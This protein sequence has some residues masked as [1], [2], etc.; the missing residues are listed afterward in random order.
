MA[1]NPR[2]TQ[3]ARS[4]RQIGA[5]IAR[6]RHQRGWT[7]SDL[8]TQAG[9]RQATISAIETGQHPARI[10]SLLA[11]LAA[12]DL[13]FRIGPRAQGQAQDIEDIF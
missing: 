6:A 3:L 4:P 11:V 9:L 12:L 7:Q 10:D 8:A 2:M 13:E 1:H 5:A